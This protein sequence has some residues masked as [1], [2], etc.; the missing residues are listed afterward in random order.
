MNVIKA[1]LNELADV[2]PLFDQY[3]QFYQQ[4]SDPVGAEAFLRARLVGGE[5]AI[6]IAYREGKAVG[7]VQLYPL[8]SSVA[9]QRTWCLNDLFVAPAHG[10]CG[11]ATALMAAARDWGQATGAKSLALAT[12]RDNQPAKRLYEGLGYQLDRVFDHYRLP[13]SP[14]D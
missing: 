8:F 11:V 4:P 14:A 10:R 13:L 2:V 7:F 5:S 3:R 6:F 9:M 1:T 12:A